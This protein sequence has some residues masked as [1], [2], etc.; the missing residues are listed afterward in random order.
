MKRQDVVVATITLARS[1]AEAAVLEGAL[2]A[3]QQHGLPILVT[4]GGSDPRFVQRLANQP[5]MNVGVSTYG[6]GLVGQVKTS[7]AAAMRSGASAILYTEPDKAGFF[8]HHL[9]DLIDH[10]PEPPGTG[11]VLAA[12]SA[13]SF[14]TFPPFQR[15][16]EQAINDMCGRVIGPSGDYSYG[17]FVI[18]TA[19]VTRILEFP[20]DLGWGWRHCAFGLAARLGY[21][22]VHAVA[23][24]PCPKEQRSE[25]RQDRAHR[26]Q[27]LQDNERGLLL[28]QTLPAE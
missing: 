14:A 16:T 9:L 1:D 7:L 12:R 13:E 28:S 27:Q 21:P 25:D 10:A 4:D 2:R 18:D 22:L 11:V 8:A 3:L 23:D 15:H 17:P 5:N 26:L 19:F 6:P 24:L 20:N